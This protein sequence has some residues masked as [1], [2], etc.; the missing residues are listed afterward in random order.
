MQSRPF[1]CDKP[2]YK[3]YEEFDEFSVPI[4]DSF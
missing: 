4:A 1:K 3:Y 2:I